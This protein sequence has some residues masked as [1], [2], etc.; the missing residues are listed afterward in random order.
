MGVQQAG[1]VAPQTARRTNDGEDQELH[2]HIQRGADLP[3]LL[4]TVAHTT[5]DLSVLRPEWRPIEVLGVGRCEVPQEEQA[6]I[7]QE[8]FQRLVDYRSAGHRILTRPNYDLLRGIGEWVLGNSVEQYVPLL[9][10]E[11]VINGEDLRRPQW[12]KATIAPQR[13][14]HVAIVGAGESGIIAAVR[15]KQAGIPFTIYEKN[16]DVGGTWL[17]NDYPGC[18]VDINSFV[19]SYAS[20]SRVWAE[21]FGTQR[22]V[23]AYLQQVARDNDLYERIKFGVEVVEASWQEESDS[24]GLT[25]RSEDRVEQ[26]TSDMLVFA[27]GQL[28]RPK[29]PD[30]RGVEKFEGISFHSARWD[31]SVDMS[32]KKVGVIGTGASACQFIPQVAAMASKVSVFARTATWLLP[33]PDLHDRVEGSARWLL[34]NLPGYA[35]WYRA[36]LL[37]YQAP[38][39]LDQVVVDKTYL[40]DERAVSSANDVARQ[41]LQAWLEPQISDRPD[42]REAVIPKSPVGSKR[43]LRDNGTWIRTLKRDN[44]E[45]IRSKIN[46]ITERGIRCADGTHHDF[47]IILYGTGF[48]ASQFLFPIN[49]KGVGG[50][51]LADRWK[52]GPR[53]YLGMTVPQFPNMFCMYGPNTN[54]VVHGASIVLFSELTAKYIVDAVRLLLETGERKMEV[55]EG[56]FSTYNRRVDEANRERAWGHSN[57]NSWYKDDTGRVTQNYPFTTPE[58]FQRTSAVVPSDFRF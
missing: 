4:M 45:V 39:L 47:D 14:F 23:L 56:V 13:P 26:F 2:L 24:W 37:M 10:E 18:R 41:H 52:D 11:L 33:T 1:D 40:A 49:V 57:V 34:E 16:S 9:A 28:N 12:T 21:Y 29:L 46:E 22:E 25:V 50:C 7:R 32:G 58:F 51:R 15:L 35:Q 5:G 19:Y 53:A 30:L 55:R 42:L 3:V 38:G 31:H 48:H 36:S 17:E 54:L 20:A 43:I 8:C 6:K 44:V 27:V